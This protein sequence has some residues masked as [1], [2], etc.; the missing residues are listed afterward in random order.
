M[1]DNLSYEISTFPSLGLV[2]TWDH[3]PS[4]NEPSVHRIGLCSVKMA[5][6]N[7][8]SRALL[9]KKIFAAGTYFSSCASVDGIMDGRKPV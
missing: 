6:S 4:G 2:F 9:A 8:C 1:T 7:S 3:L 5:V